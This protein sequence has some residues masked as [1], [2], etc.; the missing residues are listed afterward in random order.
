MYAVVYVG[1]NGSAVVKMRRRKERSSLATGH[2]LG[3][4][5]KFVREPCYM[6]TK[7]KKPLIAFT[8]RYTY[9][10]NMCGCVC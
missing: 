4:C 6:L 10:M 2:N 8:H 5:F 7:R 9:I 1:I 3:Q